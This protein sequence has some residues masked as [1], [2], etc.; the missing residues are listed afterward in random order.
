MI[1]FFLFNFPILISSQSWDF[2]KFP[3]A[4]VPPPIVPAW[5]D[6][7]KISSLPSNLP[8]VKTPMDSISYPACPARDVGTSGCDWSCYNCTRPED[9]LACPSKVDFYNLKC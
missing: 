6:Y 3:K 4:D 9:V 2:S 5:S 7:Y 8:P 1:S